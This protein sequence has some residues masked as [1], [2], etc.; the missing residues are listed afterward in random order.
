MKNDRQPLMPNELPRLMKRTILP[1]EQ[2]E[3]APARQ[4]FPHSHHRLSR[5]G[6]GAIAAQENAR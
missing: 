1:G 3:R 2:P 5:R 6:R 4:A